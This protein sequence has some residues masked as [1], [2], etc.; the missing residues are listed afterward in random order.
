[1]A[2]KN[3][4]FREEILKACGWPDMAESEIL[5]AWHWLI[6]RMYRCSGLTVIGEILGVDVN[7]IQRDL[8]AAGVT[9][10]PRGGNNCKPWIT[11]AG[12][13]PAEYAEREGVSVMTA[14]HRRYL[15]LR[16][17]DRLRR[18]WAHLLA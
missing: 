4:K 15:A 5:P 7:L 11:I 10:R 6:S 9:L 13:P 2:I 18:K 12:L 3:L 1:M 14:Y 17:D 8:R 16:G